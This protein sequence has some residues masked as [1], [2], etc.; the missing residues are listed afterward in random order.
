M[1]IDTILSTFPTTSGA[2]LMIACLFH[3][4]FLN[5]LELNTRPRIPVTRPPVKQILKITTSSIKL[6][7]MQYR[8][9]H[10]HEIILIVKA[11]PPNGALRFSIIGSGVTEFGWWRYWGYGI[12]AFCTSKP[13]FGHVAALSLISF[14]HSGHLIS[15]ISFV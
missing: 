14:P 4:T 3:L 9:K 11:I 12:K 13:Q 6:P 10:I 5:P 15:A 7:K 1:D 2:M 8:N